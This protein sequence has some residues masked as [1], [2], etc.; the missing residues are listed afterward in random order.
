[1]QF[2]FSSDEGSSCH[3]VTKHRKKSA[4][5][6]SFKDQTT[7]TKTATRGLSEA[8]LQKYTSSCDVPGVHTH[9]LLFLWNT[10]FASTVFIGILH[11]LFAAMLRK[12]KSSEGSSWKDPTETDTST[13]GLYM[14]Y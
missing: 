6:E 13:T 2:P 7:D 5:E 12:R 9:H 8:M 1:M 11:F 14:Q 4:E 3:E 10:Y